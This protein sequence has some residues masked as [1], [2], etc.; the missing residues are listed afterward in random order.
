MHPFHNN[1]M[2]DPLNIQ[3]RKNSCY[4]ILADGEFPTTKKGL[5]LI[6]SCNMLICC[7]GAVSN[8]KYYR[9]PNYII[10]DMD[11][12]SKEDFTQFSSI[13]IND[14]DQETNDM[15]KA[16]RF[17]LGT[18]K[19]IGICEGE[20]S[21]L[22]ATGK[23]EDHTIGNISLL[24]QY[25]EEL[26]SVFGNNF[27]IR[28]ITDFGEFIPLTDS[29]TFDCFDIGDKISLFSLDTSLKIKSEGLK[30]KTDDVVFDSWWKATLNTTISKKVT[31]TF[32]H[33][34]KALIFISNR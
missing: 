15:T 4:V 23:R 31:L 13:I 8:L 25:C 6:N 7:D 1:M 34:S 24:C 32:N 19:N 5:S 2:K 3:D 9:S 14:S 17:L 29:T 21:I 10:G 18:I 12:I 11:S 16:F 30:Y 28:M 20:I 27:S 33:P 26:S 22:G